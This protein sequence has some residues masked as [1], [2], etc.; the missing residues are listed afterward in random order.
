MVREFLRY[1]TP[2]VDDIFNVANSGK[3]R[4]SRRHAGF[5][6]QSSRV[7]RTGDAVLYAM[8]RCT[9]RHGRVHS[10]FASYPQE[11]FSLRR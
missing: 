1:N 3:Q 9:S 10:D 2:H 8:G 7:A 6:V 11:R 5:F 4:L